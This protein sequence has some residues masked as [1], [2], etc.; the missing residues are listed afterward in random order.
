MFLFCLRSPLFERRIHGQGLFPPGDDQTA[1]F[2]PEGEVV[3]IGTDAEGNR[4]RGPARLQVGFDSEVGDLQ[5]FRVG[6]AGFQ[7]G[8]FCQDK[9]G[10][11]GQEEPEGDPGAVV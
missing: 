10:I 3:C 9:G 1:V 11:F 7:V 4:V 5:A 6:L 2:A 8:V